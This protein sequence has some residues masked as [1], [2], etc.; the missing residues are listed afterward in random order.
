M[1]EQ[2]YMT[3]VDFATRRKKA[4]EHWIGAAVSVIIGVT[5]IIT[6]HNGWSIAVAAL[7]GCS[8]FIC[9]QIASAQN[10]FYVKDE[11]KKL[12]LRSRRFFLRSRDPRK[13]LSDVTFATILSWALPR[14]DRTHFLSDVIEELRGFRRRGMTTFWRRVYV[15]SEVSSSVFPQ[16]RR[17]IGR[18]IC[19][20]VGYLWARLIG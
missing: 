19:A 16:W 14:R 4:L 9:Y 17:W 2:E 1:S 8:S 7:C 6:F 13:A 18:A 12:F 20:A 5:T 11:L 10:A 15:V 3:R